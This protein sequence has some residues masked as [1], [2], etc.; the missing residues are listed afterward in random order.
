M[1]Q[2]GD[3]DCN[4]TAGAGQ[5]EAFPRLGPVGGRGGRVGWGAGGDPTRLGG[6]AGLGGVTNS[7]VVR[8]A[9]QKASFWACWPNYWPACLIMLDYLPGVF[10]PGGLLCLFACP[11]KRF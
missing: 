1:A 10:S 2:A 5:A 8:K 9:S 4:G 3:F 7:G 6:G 11:A